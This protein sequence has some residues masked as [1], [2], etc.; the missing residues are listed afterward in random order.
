MKVIHVSSRR[1]KKRKNV[2]K[3][4]KRLKTLNKER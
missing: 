1:N 3:I 4:K 2:Q